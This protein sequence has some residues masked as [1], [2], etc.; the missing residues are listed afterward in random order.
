MNCVVQWDVVTIVW[1]IWYTETLWW[2]DD[3]MILIGQQT[4]V[5]CALFPHDASSQMAD[6]FE[7]SRVNCLEFLVFR[8]ARFSG[9]WSVISRWQARNWGST[10][11]TLKLAKYLIGIWFKHY[12]GKNETYSGFGN[13]NEG[14]IH[15]TYT[16]PWKYFHVD[17]NEFNRI[18]R[19]SYGT[20]VIK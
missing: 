19:H 15:I 3:L 16:I 9:A 2:S 10:V 4:R 13:A 12:G 8:T 17:Q 14:I 7:I 11:L 18:S 1:N 6:R 20:I 5:G